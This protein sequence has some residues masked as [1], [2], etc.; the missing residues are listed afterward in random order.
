MEKLLRDDLTYTLGDL[1]AAR[2]AA[3][4][5]L[6]E[7]F[8]TPQDATDQPLSRPDA[9]LLL[10]NLFDQ[11]YA[12]AKK[13]EEVKAAK[14]AKSGT[15]YYS[16]SNTKGTEEDTAKEV[17]FTDILKEY[18]DAITWAYDNGIAQGVTETEFGTYNTTRRAF[19]TM[20]LNALGYQKRFQ[21]A[22]ALDFA[23]SIG[24][25]P[26][27]ISESFTLG[28]AALYLQFAKDLT[29]TNRYGDESAA[30]NRMN[31]PD[32]V[33]QIPFPMTVSVTPDT[34][35]DVETLL[36]EATAYVPRSVI[37]NGDR[38]TK[39]ELYAIYEQYYTLEGETWYTPRIWDEDPVAVYMDTLNVSELPQDERE[40]LVSFT[41][42]LHE[43]WSSGE[44]DDLTFMNTGDLERAKRLNSG[45]SVIL[46]FSYN[47]AWELACDADDAFTLYVSDQISTVADSFYRRHV[48]D[49]RNDEEAVTMAK[50][51][52]L[53]KAEYAPPVDRDEGGPIY[54]P[55][56]HSILGF[57]KNGRI[58]C[59]GYAETFQYL[60]HRA[61][62]DCV[63][64]YGSTTAKANAEEGQSDHSWN[65]V[66]VNGTWY[67]M[68]VCWADTGWPYT[69]DLRSDDYYAK[70]RH[71]AVNFLYL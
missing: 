35:D 64:V 20:L 2:F 63:M 41:A 37:I 21:P 19:V 48:A 55:E 13:A 44:I 46:E 16:K 1:A 40:E 36:K 4:G 69:Y 43:R 26:P 6:D 33:A 31:L 68:D 38:L 57:F 50:N 71:W 11:D 47:D 23:D 5:I 70:H 22:E 28:D 56:A 58:V 39:D 49:A 30:R 3:Y 14:K 29:I 42:D 34:P 61:G 53:Y 45:R 51:A 67:N 17:P 12:K 52:I 24:L 65:K 54:A 27:G 66:K 62:V 60:M 10:R 15:V 9:V 8:R 32:K 18:T 25:A 59:D 7:R